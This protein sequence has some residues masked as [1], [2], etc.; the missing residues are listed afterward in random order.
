MVKDHIT[1]GKFF[2]MWSICAVSL[3]PQ[4]AVNLGATAAAQVTVHKE[5][6]STREL[7]WDESNYSATPLDKT[8]THVR[9]YWL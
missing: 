8:S 1:Y 9:H 7:Y 5:N 4:R 3:F 6:I 2:Q